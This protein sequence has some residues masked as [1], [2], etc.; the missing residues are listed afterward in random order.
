[1]VMVVFQQFFCMYLI[2]M[3]NGLKYMEMHAF[4]HMCI[5]V[6]KK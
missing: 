3:L 4:L 6:L 2:A 5:T 1:M